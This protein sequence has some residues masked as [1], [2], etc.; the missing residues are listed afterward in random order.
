MKAGLIMAL[1]G[2]VLAGAIL[3]GGLRMY[4]EMRAARFVGL[5][6]PSDDTEPDPLLVAWF[7]PN[8]VSPD[9]GPVFDA[10]G[11]R[12]NG[13]PRPTPPSE[14]D[15]MVGGSTAY[16][17]DAPDDQTIPAFL[18]TNLRTAGDGNAVVLNAGYPGMT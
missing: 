15:A 18:E 2:L 7:K 12:L 1:I 11:F 3:E 5:A 8:Y 13:S 14:V 16:G 10:N 9:N 17:W 4:A 6:T